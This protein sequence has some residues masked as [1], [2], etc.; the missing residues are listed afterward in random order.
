MSI[1]SLARD[2]KDLRERLEKKIKSTNHGAWK[3]VFA[4]GIPQTMKVY[5]CECRSLK[6]RYYICRPDCKPCFNT[7]PD[8]EFLRKGCVERGEKCRI[9]EISV[10]DLGVGINAVVDGTEVGVIKDEE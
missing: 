2:V 9:V 3:F 10:K 8:F 5:M 1:A 7:G 6:G 4:D